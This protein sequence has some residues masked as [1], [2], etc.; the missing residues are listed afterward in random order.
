MRKNLLD[1]LDGVFMGTL[2]MTAFSLK[3][4]SDSLES[5]DDFVEG[6]KDPALPGPKARST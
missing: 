6:R 2:R 5:K 4:E 3:S 1:H